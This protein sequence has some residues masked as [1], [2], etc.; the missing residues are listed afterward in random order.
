LQT[1]LL[2]SPATD[3]GHHS[4][5]RSLLSHRPNLL[6]TTRLSLR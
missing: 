4:L 5:H 3:I 6:I 1:F 2:P